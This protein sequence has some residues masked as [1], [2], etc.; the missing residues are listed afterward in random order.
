MITEKT[1]LMPWKAFNRLL[2]MQDICLGFEDS[3]NLHRRI[4]V[5]GDPEMIT[6]KEALAYLSPNMEQDDPIKA[7]WVLRV[8][9]PGGSGSQFG[10]R[11]SGGGVSRSPTT[12]S[13]RSLS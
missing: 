8:G 3:T 13:L 5:K 1:G 6:Y 12:M 9:G 10:S 11:M 4:K 7:T 2:E